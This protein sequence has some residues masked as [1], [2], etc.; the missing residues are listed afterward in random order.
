M[1][2]LPALYSECAPQVHPTTM[3]AV[4]HVE[5]RG[6]VLAINVNR[7]PGQAT[8]PRPP[9]PQTVDEAVAVAERFINAGHS[10]DVGLSQLNSR[11]LPG[12]RMTLR[13]AF[14]QPCRN[15]AGGASILA[16]C[17]DRAIRA[18]KTAGD[19]ALAWALSCYNAGPSITG[20]RVGYISL[21]GIL[22]PLSPEGQQTLHRTLTVTLT[23]P[24]TPQRP[25]NPMTASMV[26]SGWDGMIER[27]P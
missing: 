17:Y 14:E 19:P 24:P 20:V 15:L 4:V 16:D 12:L 3:A 13:E 11:N 23:P 25:V 9:Q 22:P 10:V 8:A 6:R 21:Y 1:I 7:K 18:G 27:V 2:D 26:V 5:S